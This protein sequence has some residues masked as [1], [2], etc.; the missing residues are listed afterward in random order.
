MNPTNL[1][2]IPMETLMKLPHDAPTSFPMSLVYL[3]F[4]DS[5]LRLKL[6]EAWR[7]L[8]MTNTA[9]TKEDKEALNAQI[10][11]V[12]IPIFEKEYGIKIDRG[13]LARYVLARIYRK[14]YLWDSK[15]ENMAFLKAE[16]AK[17]AKMAKE[18]IP[19]DLA[20]LLKKLEIEKYEDYFDT[21][22][23]AYVY[24]NTVEKMQAFR[25]SESFKQVADGYI[26]DEAIESFPK[27]I[28]ESILNCDPNVVL[29]YQIA[30]RIATIIEYDEV[31]K[32]LRPDT[33]DGTYEAV[34][35]GIEE[36]SKYPVVYQIAWGV[37]KYGDLKDL[38]YFLSWGR[39]TFRWQGY[40]TTVRSSILTHMLETGLFGYLQALEKAQDAKTTKER[41][42]WN[43]MSK[44]AFCV[45]LFHDVSEVWTD[46]IPSPAKD[47]MGIREICEEQERLALQKHFYSHL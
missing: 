3:T 24:K 33:V 32:N 34:Y 46:D 5:V 8:L 42:Y 26:S 23:M 1:P 41:E 9:F 31:A 38:F 28:V 2:N 39:F 35:A 27:W 43:E 10:A 12:L 36:Y 22:A 37:G 16:V 29:I 21:S 20:K 44:K 30:K 45:G 7:G 19:E 47:G 13:E 15:P 4:A 11:L 25:D 6:N 14:S 17:M 18:G 40:A